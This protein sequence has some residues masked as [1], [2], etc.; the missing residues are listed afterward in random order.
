MLIVATDDR[1]VGLATGEDLND[2]IA[3][4]EPD[5]IRDERI[6]PALGDG[7][8]AGGAVGAAEGPASRHQG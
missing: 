6:L 1:E 5:L 8:W 3:P 2:R 7:D 4:N